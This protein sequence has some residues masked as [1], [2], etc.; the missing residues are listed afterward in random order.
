MSAANGN[1]GHS[2][3]RLPIRV[4][5]PTGAPDMDVSQPLPGIAVRDS[6]SSGRPDPY[7]PGWANGSTRR[8]IG[9]DSL[10]LPSKTSN[11]EDE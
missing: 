3:E 11:S 8:A 6:V 5:V 9:Q 7:G 4:V 10:G 2:T 1:S